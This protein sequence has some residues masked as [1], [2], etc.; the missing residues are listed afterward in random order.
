MLVDDPQ[1]KMVERVFR[2]HGTGHAVDYTPT[3]LY[4]GTAMLMSGRLVL[5][6]F[7]DTRP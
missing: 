7:E 2:I 4:V 3:L 5:H 6:V 1:S